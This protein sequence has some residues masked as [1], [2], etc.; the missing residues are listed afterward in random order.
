VE[1]MRK[2]HEVVRT[3]DHFDEKMVKLRNMLGPK[4]A[5]EYAALY[6]LSSGYCEGCGKDL[7]VDCGNDFVTVRVFHSG[8][9]DHALAR[10]IPAYVGI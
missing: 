6:I 1:L 9:P 3:D 2:I 7:L 5:D 8:R 10:A 4:D